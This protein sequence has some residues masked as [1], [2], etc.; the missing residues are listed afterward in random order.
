M[1]TTQAKPKLEIATGTVNY[2]TDLV[3]DREAK[4]GQSA[5][6]ALIE[7]A[8][9][10]ALPTTTQ[11]DASDMIDRMKAK[12]RRSVVSQ[13]SSLP[14]SYAPLAPIPDSIQN[15]KYAIPTEVLTDLRDAWRSQSLLFLE[16]KVFR[17][18]RTIRRLTGAPGKFNRTWLSREERAEI[19]GLL[20]DDDFA[21]DAMMRFGEHYKVCGRCAA[22]LTDDDSRE[23][24]LG[25][26]CWKIVQT[27]WKGF[28]PA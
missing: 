23:R 2:L 19:L 11:K 10:L 15:S 3:R 7:L 26:R 14:A 28:T 13:A 16:V 9:W 1:T 4:P 8:K 27:S 25:L 5:T 21:W 22:E 18:K 17:G 20:E 6:D 24:K 12:P